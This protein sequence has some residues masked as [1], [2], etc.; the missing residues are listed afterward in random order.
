MSYNGYRVRVMHC[1][2]GSAG[3]V[4]ALVVGGGSQRLQ[5]ID[6]L[7]NWSRVDATLIASAVSG[8]PGQTGGERSMV[9]PDA[10]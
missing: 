10:T 9:D 3:F 5:R 2:A 6:V 8:P 4:E 7:L 1:E